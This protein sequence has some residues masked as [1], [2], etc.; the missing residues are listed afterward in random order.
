M[1]AW[2][3][4]GDNVPIALNEV[5]EPS[6]GPGD[7]LIRVMA[8]GICHSDVGFLDGTISSLLGSRPITL[9]HESAGVVAALGARASGFHVGDRVAVRSAIEGPGC[10]RDGGFQKLVA[11]QSELLVRIPDEVAWDQAAVSTDAGGTAYRAVI[12]RGEV[13]AGDKVGIIGMGG[14]G[15][16]AVQMARGV[17]ADVYVAEIN[18]ALHDYARELGVTAVSTGLA[19]FRDVGLNV[20][21]DFAGFGTTTADAIDVVAEF[22]RVVQVGLGH[23]HGTLNLMNLTVKQVTLLG[24]LGG[25]NQDNASVLRMMADGL[26][27]SRTTIIGFDEIGE[28]LD[29]LQQGVAL[30]RLVALY[31]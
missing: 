3:Y 26:L 30:G 9:G 13:K 25:S 2:Q 5:Q 16:L 21:V 28:A 29:K 18:P 12:T 8:A 15:S 6:V 10:G 31:P 24:S 17:G 14:L 20:I 27:T 23:N 4:T 22:G 7:V 1:Q 19:D 11:A